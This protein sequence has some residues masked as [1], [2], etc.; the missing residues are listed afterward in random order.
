[1]ALLLA[2]AIGYAVRTINAHDGGPAH[3]SPSVSTSR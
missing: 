3:P 2:L 1:V